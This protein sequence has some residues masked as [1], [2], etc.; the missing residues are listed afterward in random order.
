MASRRSSCPEIR[1]AV[2]IAFGTQARLKTLIATRSPAGY[3]I[4]AANIFT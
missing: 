1:H 3:F 4:D 2:A